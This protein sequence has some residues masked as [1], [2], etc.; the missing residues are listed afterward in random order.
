MDTGFLKVLMC[1]GGGI[2]SLNDFMASFIV[3]FLPD[4]KT[5]LSIRLERFDANSD[6]KSRVSQNPFFYILLILWFQINHY[7]NY[8]KTLKL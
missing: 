7:R 4:A 2:L 8:H 3:T 6:V 5:F 1:R